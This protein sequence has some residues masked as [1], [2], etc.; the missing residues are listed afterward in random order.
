MRKRR[1]EVSAGSS[2][3]A[4]S[5]VPDIIEPPAAVERLVARQ[6][7]VGTDDQLVAFELLHRATPDIPVGGRVEETV[8]VSAFLGDVEVD[9][10]Q[11]V[12][13]LQLFCEA[14][15]E[16][17]A[18]TTTVTLPA[19]RTVL[20]VPAEVAADP[21]VVERCRA[22][23]ADG[24]SIAVDRLSWCEGIESLLELADAA[25]IDLETH[26][27]QEVLDLVFRCRPFDVTLLA[28]RCQT[29]QD[30]VWAAMAGFELFQGAAVQRPVE[31][32]GNTLAPSALAQVQLATELLDE[33]V[34][35]SRVEAILAHE[36][37]LVV[38]VLHYASLGADGGLRREV[39]SVREALVLLGTVRLRQWAALT[40]LG[41]QVSDVRTDA[42]A[43]ALVR[44]RMC[45]LLA[46]PRGIERSFAFTAG[47][48]S[49]LDRLL[50]VSIEEVESRV[51]IDEAL[52]AAAFRRET[53][54][55]ELVGQVTDYQDSVDS[56]A[57]APQALGDVALIAAMSFCW[58]MHHIHAI[59]KS[60][61]AA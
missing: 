39:H 36:P 30:L 19:E 10:A 29:E 57:A 3:T 13:E 15:P 37:A 34:D 21:E 35:F 9:V 1:S 20:L 28:A 53:P 56:A 22:L 12:G 54:L 11:L 26:T 31:V 40:V 55:G 18:G 7:I 44:A 60:R 33:R 59:E 6:P 27:R 50:G 46:Q 58:A 43:V 4:L 8:T 49:A 23:V 42:L 17:L 45:E 51:D 48:L 52:A 24:Y 38:Q 2:T 5:A 47:L 61:A 14:A 16:V 32:S 25:K 41:R